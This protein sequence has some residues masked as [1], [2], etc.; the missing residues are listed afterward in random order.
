MFIFRPEIHPKMKTYTPVKMVTI[1]SAFLLTQGDSFSTRWIPQG[2][3]IALNC[4]SFQNNIMPVWMFNGRTIYGMFVSPLSLNISNIR[5]NF[6]DGRNSYLY[7]ERFAIGNIGNYTCIANRVTRCAYYLNIFEI[8][9]LVMIESGETITD[10]VYYL[11]KS[12]ELRLTCLTKSSFSGVTLNWSL[13]DPDLKLPRLVSKRYYLNSTQIHETKLN[14][15]LMEDVIVNCHLNYGRSKNLRNLSVAF[16]VNSTNTGSTIL[17]PTFTQGTMGIVVSAG[18]VLVS[19]FIAVPLAVLCKKRT[20]QGKPIARKMSKSRQTIRGQL[21]LNLTPDNFETDVSFSYLNVRTDEI[22]IEDVEL[23]SMLPS[24]DNFTYWKATCRNQ[25]NNGYIIAKSVSDNARMEDAYNF[26]SA[27]KKIRQLNQHPNIV[28]FLGCSIENVPCYIYLEFLENGTLQ[29]LL[30]RS[31]QLQ[32][33]YVNRG[34][35][36][37]QPTDID[38]LF[39]FARDVGSGLEFLHMNELCHPGLSTNKILLDGSNKCK[40][41]DFWPNEISSDRL[42]TLLSVRN[43]PIG[44]LPPESVFMNQYDSISD[45]WSYG[46][47]LWEIFSFG[48]VPYKSE[49]K[50]EIEEHIRQ[51]DLLPRPLYCPSAMF[52][53]MLSTWT[54]TRETRPMISEVR[55]KLDEI[56]ADELPANIT[57]F[58]NDYFILETDADYGLPYGNI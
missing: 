56:S 35:E 9:E 18:G 27:A 34:E 44:W 3:S 52:D 28:A 37:G 25:S 47:L 21:D 6:T 22:S 53:I 4:T 16:S 17:N 5:G 13:N 15:T 12:T 30:L 40:L 46:V 10:D 23:I 55:S 50:N 38:S 51:S 41:Y 57:T 20:K 54:Q 36:Y 48:E 8:P 26:I 19:L 43:P 14:F 24:V 49:S 39:G 1:F 42:S 11:Q 7:I 2:G 58:S 33:P 29:D 32:E 45:I 31:D